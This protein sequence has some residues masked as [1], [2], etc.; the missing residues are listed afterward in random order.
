MS[1]CPLTQSIEHVALKTKSSAT[2]SCGVRSAS[3]TWTHKQSVKRSTRSVWPSWRQNS[4]PLRRT[5]WMA[6]CGARL[7][8]AIESV[9][10]PNA[11][12]MPMMINFAMSERVH[13][14]QWSGIIG[15]G[16]SSA[17][18][19]L[20]DTGMLQACLGSGYR[21]RFLEEPV[22]LW[23]QKGWLGKFYA[24]TDHYALAFQLIVF[25]T[26]V[27]EVEALLAEEAATNDTRP[28]I[29]IAE[30]SMLDERLFWQLQVD[31]G[32]YTADEMHDDAYTG[33]WKLWKRFVPVPSLIVLFHTSDIQLTMKRLQ[34]RGRSEEVCTALNTGPIVEVGG[35]TTEYQELLY[36]K[37]CEWFATPMAQPPTLN[38]T[39]IPCT[40]INVDAPYHVSDG[41][42]KELADTMAEA[43]LKVIKN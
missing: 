36:K 40:H 18:R 43:I 10:R 33:I 22:E 21:V 41:S 12:V 24:D 28:L 26:H 27:A 20:R 8:T 2:T 3:P 7:F 19:R 31:M 37:H 34:N 1:L 42:L 17:L 9:W 15:C 6:V 16:K 5:T 32:R 35:L 39:G 13:L 38:G 14:V 23:R 29:I 11:S 4:A 30:R 25:E